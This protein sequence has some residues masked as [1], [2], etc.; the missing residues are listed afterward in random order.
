MTLQME[1]FTPEPPPLPDLA[2]TDLLIAN[3]SAGKD[4]QAM[5]HHLVQLADMAGVLDRVHV[6]HCDLGDVEWPGTRELA[7]AQARHY[8][9]PF[10]VVHRPQGDLLTQIADRHRDLRARGDTTTP[11]WPSSSA[12]YC[13]SGQKR[14]PVRVLITKLVTRLD[15]ARPAR[16]LN[17]LGLRAAESAARARRPDIAL[18]EGGS[19]G[20]RT[21]T[22]WLPILRWSDRQVWQAIADAGTPYHPAYDS[23]MRRL[24]C[25][26]CVLADETSLITAARLRPQLAERYLALEEELGHTFKHGLSMAQ[27][28]ARAR[29][30]GPLPLRADGSALRMALAA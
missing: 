1:L 28:V 7:E 3:S 14:G 25:T 19:S 9:L 15:L 8:G 20:R 11:A 29:R 2:E 26:F 16:V 21:I 6:V 4:S 22:T 27:I 18:D 24:S 5:L 30:L 23:G 12:R 10:H 13:T 17:C